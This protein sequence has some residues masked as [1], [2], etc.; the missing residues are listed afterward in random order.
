DGIR[1]RNVTGV[2]TCAL[3]ILLEPGGI[4][5][6]TAHPGGDRSVVG[7]AWLD[8]YRLHH[9]ISIIHATGSDT[10]RCP[11]SRAAVSHRAPAWLVLSHLMHRRNAIP[12]RPAAWST[13]HGFC[14]MGRQRAIHPVS[15]D[16]HAKSPGPA[17]RDPGHVRPGRVHRRGRARGAGKVSLALSTV[18]TSAVLSAPTGQD[19]KSTRLNS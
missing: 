15:E 18:Q 2:Q 17:P 5:F 3:P 14:P 8:C 11:P 9:R 1:D 4:V 6:P 13:G 10:S 16:P 12:R 19:R 7:L